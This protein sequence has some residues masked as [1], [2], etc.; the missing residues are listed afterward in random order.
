MIT[1]TLNLE[2]EGEVHLLQQFVGFL[3]AARED[4]K[5]R[6]G[7]DSPVPP[8]GELVKPEEPAPAVNGI[9]DPGTAVG[10]TTADLEAA[11]MDF[12]KKN[13]TPAAVELLASFGI[14]RLPELDQKDYARMYAKCYA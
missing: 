11:L 1:V 9:V 5:T 13:G 6:G 7:F 8:G 3:R 14:K 10:I 2:H 12:A 4:W